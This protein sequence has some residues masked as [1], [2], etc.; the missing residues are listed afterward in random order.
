[1]S[2]PPISCLSTF[3]KYWPC[4]TLSSHVS[5]TDSPKFAFTYWM[6]SFFLTVLSW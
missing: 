6:S 5:F 3:T 2:S 4:S 1:V